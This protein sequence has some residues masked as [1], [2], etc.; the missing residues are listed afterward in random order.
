MTV[1]RYRDTVARSNVITLAEEQRNVARARIERAAAEVLRDRGLA[2][3]V[4][5]VAAAAG[6][7]VRTVFRHYGTRDH[8][9]VTA[10]RAQLRRYRDTLPRPAA[11]AELSPWLHDLLV[12]IHR[13]NADLGHAYWELAALGDSLEG[14][15]AELAAVRR[16]A[17][18]KLVNAV[19]AT[20][21]DLA[22]GRGRP[23]RWLTDVF[24]IHLSSF[25][26]RA[27]VADF[28]RTPDDVAEA[29][30]RALTAALEAA[31][32]SLL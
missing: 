5:E 17:R 22:G 15:F 28:G 8:M 30:T 18:T 32:A 25:A 7:S 23:P 24:A 16:S 10:L 11:D 3:T 20:A 29:S 21:W 2:A 12:E 6:V 19:T 31:T 4:E 26:T 9:V 1:S 27:L 14:E 13:L